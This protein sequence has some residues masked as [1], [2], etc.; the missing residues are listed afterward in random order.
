MLRDIM[1][2]VNNPILERLFKMGLEEIIGPLGPLRVAEN[3]GPQPEPWRVA[4]PQLVE[5]ATAR[6]LAIKHQ[7]KAAQ[8]SANQAIETI[9]DDWC[10]TPPRRHPW[11][12]PGPPPWA[13]QIASELSLFANTLQA[14]SLRSE[15]ETIVGRIGRTGAESR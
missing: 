2:R 8:H 14:G 4:V 1:S 15:I 6:D 10:G 12:F 13:W 5:A 9:L 7:N 3:L 11:P